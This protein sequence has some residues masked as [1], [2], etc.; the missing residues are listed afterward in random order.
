L[1]PAPP[2]AAAEDW[3]LAGARR[4]RLRLVRNRRARRYV[5]RLGP[6]GAARV[7]IPRGGSIAEARQ[8]AHRN[9]AWVEEELLRLASRPSGPRA[10]RVGTEIVF[11]GEPVRLETGGNGQ[12]G[13]VRFGDQSL[14]VPDA[15]GDLRAAVERH[16]WQL[17]ARELPA[18]LLELAAAHQIPAP[19]VRV[20]NQRS[21]WGSCS[22]RGT[23]SLNW[24]LVQTPPWVRDYLILHELAH[25]REM[26]HSRRF[27][28]E[29]ARLC[30]EFAEAE[31]WLKKHS[32]LLR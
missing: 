30:P 19:R 6:D 18:R 8:F 17:A 21:R 31:G 32:G 5:L 22:R 20:R 23:I 29:V 12:S 9:A 7:T 2:E 26:N 13:G 14:G 10:W 11:R 28:G 3:L 27:W 1:G 15:A 16:L 25:L 4:V 24:R